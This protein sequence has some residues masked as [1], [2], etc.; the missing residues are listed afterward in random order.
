MSLATESGSFSAPAVRQTGILI[1]DE[2]R[3]ALSGLR[4]LWALGWQPVYRIPVLTICIVLSGAMTVW[5]TQ[6]NL[7]TIMSCSAAI[8]VA[9]QFWHG[10]GGGLF[11][12]WYLPLLLLTVFRPNLEDRIATTVLEEGWNPARTLRVQSPDLAA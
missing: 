11:L 6:K 5:P 4:G 1:G 8:M 2:W 10:Y 9:T 12:G 7:G 3:P